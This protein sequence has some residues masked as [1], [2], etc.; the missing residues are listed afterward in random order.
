[1]RVGPEALGLGQD[2]SLQ[3]Q[4]GR[5]ER[6]Q[7]T[8]HFLSSLYGQ[9]GR[10]GAPWLAKQGIHVGQ[11]LPRRTG[12][13]SVGDLKALGDGVTRGLGSCAVPP[14]V[15]RPLAQQGLF[16]RRVPGQLA[17]PHPT[18]SLLSSPQ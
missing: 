15:L 16:A 11:G 12:K 3:A 9:G 8:Q 5:G 17:V 10:M 6:W 2:V 1:M 13:L 18:S 4:K 14:G 7:R